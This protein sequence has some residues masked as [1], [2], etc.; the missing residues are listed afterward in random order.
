MSGLSLRISVTAFSLYHYYSPVIFIDTPSNA[1]TALQ[2]SGRIAKGTGR[3]DSP[4]EIGKKLGSGGQADVST[5]FSEQ[6]GMAS[7]EPTSLGSIG[8]T[9]IEKAAIS[10]V[11]IPGQTSRH[12]CSLISFALLASFNFLVFNLAR[13]VHFGGE[14]KDGLI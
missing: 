3:L 13:T 6:H 9:S 8:S 11:A 4:Y 10:L 1:Q 7:L 2:A 14:I 5:S 12:L